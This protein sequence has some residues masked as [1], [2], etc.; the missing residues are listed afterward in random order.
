M[1]D[2]STLPRLTAPALDRRSLATF[3]TAGAFATLAFDIF[4][5]GIS[6]LLGFASLAPVP[7]A[8]SVLQSVFGIDSAP[9][10]HLLHYF[11]GMVGY[12]V[13]WTFVAAPLARRFAPSL[14][15]WAAAAT[16]GVALWVFALYIMAHLVAGLPAFLGFTGITWVALAGHVLFALVAAW[17]LRA[18]G[19]AR[20]V[21]SAA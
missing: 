13:G 15:W 16:Y 21:T 2:Q 20:S 5:Q 17:V 10:A 3:L 1:T 6:P 12:V 8:R 7:L 19:F 11:T 9:L 14:P 4:G 18:R